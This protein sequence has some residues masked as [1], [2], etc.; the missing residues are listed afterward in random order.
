MIARVTFH[1]AG[2][3]YECEAGDLSLKP[4]DRVVV[5][6]DR[7]ETLARVVCLGAHNGREGRAR[8]G[9]SSAWRAPPT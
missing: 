2:K 9:R 5:A 4:G 1:N 8:P 7:G 6:A 3:I